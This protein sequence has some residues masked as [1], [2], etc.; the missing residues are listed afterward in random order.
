MRPVRPRPSLRRKHVAAEGG[1]RGGRGNRRGGKEMGKILSMGENLFAEKSK[2]VLKTWETAFFR[3]QSGADPKTCLFFRRRDSVRIVVPRDLRVRIV[4]D[5]FSDMRIFFG[6]RVVVADIPQIEVFQDL[7]DY[8][9]GP[10]ESKSPA[11]D[12]CNWDNK[13]DRPRRF[14]WISLA[15]L[16][17]K[18]FS[19]S[20]LR[21]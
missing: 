15:H 13:T 6:R 10:R 18:L 16:R 14:F 1:R 5:E 20:I 2:C 7:F 12:D 3:T 11:F 4:V 8:R 9:A 19:M 17:R 21:A